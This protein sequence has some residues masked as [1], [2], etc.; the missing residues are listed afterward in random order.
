M[1]SSPLRRWLSV[2]I[3]A[4]IFVPVLTLLY[5]R[6]PGGN[7]GVQADTNKDKADGR[8]WP[9]FGGTLARNLVNLVE[10]D[11]PTD[12]SVKEGAEKNI[13]WSV[14]L[15]SKAYGGPVFYRGKIFIGTNNEVP[16]DPKITG[17]K[18]VLMCFQENDGKFLWQAVYD[19]L[20]AGRVQD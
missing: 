7:P 19:K 9:L 10:K 13:K 20:P 14:N 15:G 2:A 1:N 12:W 8:N 3:T 16:R 17:D 4:V 6:G 5:L 11:M 18:G